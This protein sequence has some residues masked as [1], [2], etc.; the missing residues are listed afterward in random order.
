MDGMRSPGTVVDV[1]ETLTAYPDFIT[2]EPQKILQPLFNM[3]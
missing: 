2:M 1:V 3:L